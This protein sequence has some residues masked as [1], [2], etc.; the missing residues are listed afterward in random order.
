MKDDPHTCE[1]NLCNC[2]KKPE[3]KFRTSTGFEP[4]T[5][6]YQCDAVTNSAM[7][8]L[9]LGEGQYCGFILNY[10]PMKEMNVND[11]YEINHI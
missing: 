1:R 11:V 3:K 2:V 8:P 7:K 9:T 10:V 5:S 6:R 4:V